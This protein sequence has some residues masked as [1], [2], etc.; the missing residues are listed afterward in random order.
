[1]I[2]IN[3]APPRQRK[4]LAIAWPGFT[5]GMLFGIL[6]AV[7]LLGVGGAWWRLTAEASR[8]Q[9]EIDTAQGQLAQLKVAIEEGK[10]FKAE[11]DELEKR[12]F[13]VTELTQNQVRP[14]AFLDRLAGT[15]PR[16]L[17]LASATEKDNHLRITGTAFSTGALA[18]FLV[19]LES[20]GTFKDV[21]LVVA[22]QDITK[23]SGTITFEVACRF[24]LGS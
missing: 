12:L 4:S 1:M 6:S 15:I 17:W 9:R 5:L 2:K 14:V 7:T 10:R 18:D 8:L 23:P 20:S 11:R 19:N 13:A 21:D 3:L 24:E 16:D 22:R